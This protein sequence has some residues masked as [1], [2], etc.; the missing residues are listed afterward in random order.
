MLFDRSRAGVKA[1]THQRT[2]VPAAYR[3]KTAGPGG[4]GGG[5]RGTLATF[6]YGANKKDVYN[7]T[8]QPHRTLLVP[9]PPPQA[10]TVVL[11]TPVLVDFRRDHGHF[12]FPNTLSV[13]FVLLVHECIECGVRG[14]DRVGFNTITSPSAS[15]QHPTN[16]PP[17]PTN[18]TGFYG[19]CAYTAYCGCAASSRWALCPAL[20][21]S[22]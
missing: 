8:L 22:R 16:T 15:H 21:P 14:V 7:Q 13:A 4:G 20:A 17:T 6:H 9:E 12:W 3:R 19:Y 18:T 1:R 2:C 5:P 11:E 10:P